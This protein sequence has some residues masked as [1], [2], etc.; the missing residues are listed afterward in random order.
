MWPNNNNNN[1]NN[2]KHKPSNRVPKTSMLK[3]SSP[4]IN[5]I[6]YPNLNYQPIKQKESFLAH[7]TLKT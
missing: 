5:K 6:I 2:N 7:D 3:P 1:N 4:K